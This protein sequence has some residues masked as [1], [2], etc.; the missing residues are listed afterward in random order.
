MINPTPAMSEQPVA[1][2]ARDKYCRDR[3]RKYQARKAGKHRA[4][5]RLID[6]AF[7]SIPKTERALDAPCGGGRLTAHLAGR[8]YAVTAAD[9]SEAMIEIARETLDAR[10]LACPV[11]LQDI[12]ALTY[13]D[14][15]FGTVVCFRL[16]HHFPNAEIRRRAVRALCRVADRHVVLSYLAPSLSTLKRALRQAQGGKLSNKYTSTLVEVCGYFEEAGFALVRDFAQLPLVHTLH[17]AV[18]ERTGVNPA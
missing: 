18:F 11:K 13:A 2:R 15:Q 16:F 8:G 7:A 4:E 10:G 9:L 12:E 3:A 5:M 1:C 6:R 14:R 17:V